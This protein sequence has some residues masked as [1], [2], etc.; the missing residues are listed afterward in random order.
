MLGF[1]MRTFEEF[2]L[3]APFFDD[4]APRKALFVEN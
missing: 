1:E 2:D 3:W 4:L